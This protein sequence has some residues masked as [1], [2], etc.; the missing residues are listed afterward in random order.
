MNQITAIWR[1]L[2]AEA[3]D[4]SGYAC[5]RVT[6]PEWMGAFIAVAK[7]GDRPALLFELPAGRLDRDLANRN[8][9]GFEVARESLTGQASPKERIILSLSD[10]S[11]LDTFEIFSSDVVEKVRVASDEA[12]MGTILADRIFKWRRFME[13]YD[14]GGLTAGEQQGL[15]GELLFIRDLVKAGVRPMRIL[16]AWRGPSGGNQDFVF[17]RIAFE[18]KTTSANPPERAVIS[19]ILQLDSL[20][21]DNLFLYHASLVSR[22]GG[23]GMTL[24]GL[25]EEV[26]ALALRE[27]VAS[28]A[29][30]DDCLLE[31]G[32]LEGQAGKL[33]TANYSLRHSACFRVAEGFPRLLERDLPAGVGDVKYSIEVSSLKPFEVTIAGVLARMPSEDRK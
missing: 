10:D 21:L 20:G 8:S 33:Y 7:P 12:T 3:G 15:F 22:K 16:E 17:D 29:K 23:H 1:E 30:L 13:V 18:V 26:S 4:G 6:G 32:Y 24:P 28:R 11:Y 25:V 31:A 5:R 19:N 9:R 14:P 2:A 27:S